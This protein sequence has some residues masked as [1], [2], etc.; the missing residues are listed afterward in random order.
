MHVS[1]GYL[2]QSHLRKQRTSQLHQELATQSQQQKHLPLRVLHTHTHPSNMRCLRCQQSLLKHSSKNLTIRISNKIP[3]SSDHATPTH[4][5]KTKPATQS[6]SLCGT[7]SQRMLPSG[8]D[9][10]DPCCSFHTGCRRPE[11]SCS[12]DEL[13]CTCFLTFTPAL[14]P[15]AP[16]SWTTLESK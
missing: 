8:L 12:P 9:A 5:Y 15:S 11:L 4:I 6:R 2:L 3:G 1:L 16:M 7:C 13:R 10:G 14:S